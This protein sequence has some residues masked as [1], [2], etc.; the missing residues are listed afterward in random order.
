[1][2]SSKFFPAGLANFGSAMRTRVRAFAAR[3]M[4]AATLAGALAAPI[5][6]PSG[7]FAA[8]GAGI[9]VAVVAAGAP[10]LANDPFGEADEKAAKLTNFIFKMLRYAALVGLAIVIGMGFFGNINWGTVFYI[11]AGCLVVAIAPAL[12]DWLA[13]SNFANITQ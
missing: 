7:G 2:E 5:A 13:N 3:L 6:L 8:A 9:A 10:A 1:M 4:L 11:A 12:I